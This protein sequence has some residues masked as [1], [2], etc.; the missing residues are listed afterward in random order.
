MFPWR[1][2][3]FCFPPLPLVLSKGPKRGWRGNF[4]WLTLLFYFL[5]FSN[6]SNSFLV[7]WWKVLQITIHDFRPRNGEEWQ[8]LLKLSTS[9]PRC[10]LHTS[11]NGPFLLVTCPSTNPT[12]Q[13][14][15][16]PLILLFLVFIPFPR[17][18][19]NCRNLMEYDF[20]GSVIKGI[21]VSVL[22][23]SLGSLQQSHGEVHMERKWGLLLTTSTNLPGI[24]RSCFG[25]RS[26]SHSQVLR[27]LQLWLTSWLG[28]HDRL[29]AR[30]LLD[31]WPTE[32]VR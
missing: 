4:S 23:I 9:C 25:S 1:T 10:F 5:F 3:T 6:F 13:R 16:S 27:R 20:R 22:L 15:L 18:M 12:Q 19:G 8:K 29:W 32:T 30:L 17:W 11:L 21:V 14:R 7:Y 31:S 24:W 26:F 2:Q 28:P